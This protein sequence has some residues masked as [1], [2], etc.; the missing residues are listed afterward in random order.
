MENWKNIDIKGIDGIEKCIAEFR[1]WDI[2]RTPY[3][4][5]KVKIF[6]DEK[7]RFNGFTNL[8][9]IDKIGSYYAAVGSGNTVEEAL[10]DTLNYMGEL[11]SIKEVWEESDFQCVDPFDF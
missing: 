6:E 1:I 11:L 10:E 8:Q 5:Y 9:V 2:N 7:G 4:K 3:A